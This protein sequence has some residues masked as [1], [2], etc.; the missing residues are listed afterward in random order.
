MQ[1]IIYYI[2]LGKKSSRG[3]KKIIQLL[4]KTY[5]NKEDN[6]SF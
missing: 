1:E 3:A 6:R 5:T 4:A 2:I